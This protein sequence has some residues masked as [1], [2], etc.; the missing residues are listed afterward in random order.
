MTSQTPFIDFTSQAYGFVWKSRVALASL[1]FWPF[2]I[3]FASY[4]L[5]LFFGLQDNLL[6]QGLIL[7][8]STFAEALLVSLVVRMALFGGDSRLLSDPSSR[9]VILSASIVYVLIKMLMVLVVSLP[10]LDQQNYPPA[11]D[12]SVSGYA[13]LLLLVAM[14]GF[15]LWMFRYLWLYIPLLTGDRVQDF[16]HMMKPFRVSLQAVGLSLICFMPSGIALL[17][18]AAILGALFPDSEGVS[19]TFFTFGM[20]LAQ[21][22]LELLIAVISSLAMAIFW[23]NLKKT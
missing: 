12:P 2:F 3:K 7:M 1:A 11:E 8:P 20:A 23:M 21:S 13:V 4:G 19:S 18:F 14:T 22:A 9:P 10:I 16:L 6:R 5:I 17:F 15:L